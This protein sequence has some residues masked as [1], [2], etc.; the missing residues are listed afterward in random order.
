MNSQRRPTAIVQFRARNQVTVAENSVVFTNQ[1]QK[2]PS[3]LFPAHAALFFRL[4]A[5]RL[6]VQPSLPSRIQRRGILF[7]LALLQAIDRLPPFALAYIFR[8]LIYAPHH[9]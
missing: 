5:D 4:S 7:I 1:I 8:G 2:A 3:D 6:N 9:S